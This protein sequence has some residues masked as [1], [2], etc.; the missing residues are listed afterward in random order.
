MIDFLLGMFTM[1][2]VIMTV[3]A[4]SHYK[5]FQRNDDKTVALCWGI[6]TIVAI[7]IGILF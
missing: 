3:R 5:R 6:A 4:V 7:T 1:F 2:A